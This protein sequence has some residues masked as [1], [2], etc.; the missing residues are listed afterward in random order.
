M[1][2]DKIPDERLFQNNSK[3]EIMRWGRSLRYFHYM[4]SRG[5]HNCEGDAFCAYFKYNDL[6]DLKAKMSLIGVSL[7]ELGENS[8]A[9]D[10]MKSYSLYD[11]DDLDVTI[12]RFSH[13]VQPQSVDVFGYKIHVWVLD[14]SF[15][16]SVSG[17]KEGQAYKVM[18]ED[19]QVCSE[20]ESQFDKLG[21][22]SLL[23]HEIESKPH[24]VSKNMYPELF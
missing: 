18:E 3:K 16:L 9:F 14:N 2:L 1:N 11:L 8:R 23:D 20:L 17:T 10:P 4:R 13:I 7:K 6:D 22:I 5:G 24:C 19:F 12:S 21:W 15:E